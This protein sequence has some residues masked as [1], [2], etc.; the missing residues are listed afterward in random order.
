MK[1]NEPKLYVSHHD[2]YMWEISE[3]VSKL[4]GYTKQKGA[5][6]DIEV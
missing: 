4:F 1:I 6:A 5:G 2:N 3:W